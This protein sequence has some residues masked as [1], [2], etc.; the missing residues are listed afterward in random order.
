MNENEIRARLNL[1]NI[2][3]VN[4][5]ATYVIVGTHNDHTWVR[6]SLPDLTPVRACYSE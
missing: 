5:G 6:Y 2:Y 3:F 4:I 1:D